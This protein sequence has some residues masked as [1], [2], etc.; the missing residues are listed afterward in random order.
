[1]E[2]V[3]L[4]GYDAGLM[5]L[6]ERHEMWQRL[7]HR[8]M[9]RRSR[10]VTG[11][12]G[13]RRCPSV[14]AGSDLL[15]QI[16]HVVVLMMENHS[17]DN[18]LG[19]LNGRGEGFPLGP[20]G[21][22]EAANRDAGGELVRAHHQ[23]STAQWPDLPSQSWHATH[24]QWG[25]GNCDGFVTSAQLVLSQNDSARPTMSGRAASGTGSGRGSGTGSGPAGPRSDGHG[26]LDRGRLPFY[27]GLARTFPLAD[28]WFSSC[29]G[30]TFPNR[31]FLIAGTRTGSSTT[32]HPTCS[33]T[34]GRDH[35]RHADQARHLLGQLPSG[36]RGRLRAD[37]LC[38]SQAE[39][40]PPPAGVREPVIP[41]RTHGV[42]KDLQFTADVFPFGIGKYMQHVRQTSQFFTDA[43]D[44]TLPAFSIV[45]PDFTAYSEEN[46]QDIRKGE[47]FAAEVISRVMHGRGGRTP[48]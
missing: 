31:R 28:H 19:M 1:M 45:D 27:Y 32:R 41:V 14:P 36:R 40:G 33:T 47:S 17:Y 34:P 25:G 29:L 42:Q 43:D 21:K 8:E 18:Y 2:A 4:P 16:R 30:P 37:A 46:P 5:S 22:P 13:P 24:L 10:Q 12:P 3:P 9:K 44:G 39:N 48:C 15:P 20:D 6:E 35:L 23:P 26:L 38:P 11:Q 7:E